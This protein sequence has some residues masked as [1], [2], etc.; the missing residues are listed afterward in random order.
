MKNSMR[1]QASTGQNV[2]AQMGN[3]HPVMRSGAP[4]P[5]SKPHVSVKNPDDKYFV[6][7]KSVVGE[8]EIIGSLRK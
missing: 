1:L 5:V 3:L 2:F 6:V 7:G 4:M 8:D